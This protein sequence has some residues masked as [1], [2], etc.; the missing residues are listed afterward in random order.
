MIYL[1][2]IQR[3]KEWVNFEIEYTQNRIEFPN[4]ERIG[5]YTLIGGA[6]IALV[7]IAILILSP[8]EPIAYTIEGIRNQRLEPFSTISSTMILS[9]IIAIVVSLFIFM[10]I[11]RTANKKE[12]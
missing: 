12:V 4:R 1:N 8:S 9:G 2:R 11:D 3:F 6:I 5:K 7:G 10:K